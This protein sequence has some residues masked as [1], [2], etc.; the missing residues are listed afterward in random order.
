MHLAPVNYLA[1]L[2]AAI[3]QWL[4]GW[5]WYS[6]LFAKPWKAMVGA[7]L[8]TKKNNMALA[9]V[10]SFIC[11]LVLCF[12]LAHLVLWAGT[13]ALTWGLLIGVIV[14]AAFIAA[15]LTVQHI[16]ECRPFNLYAINTGYWLVALVIS[17][18]LL[19]VWH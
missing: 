11:S 14:W 13:G 1:V 15:P 16:Y 2:V 7:G 5:L 9:M 17:G 3:I 12:V 18:G 19:A 4:L 10:L 6:V 8:E